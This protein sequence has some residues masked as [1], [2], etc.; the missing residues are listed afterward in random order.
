[1]LEKIL[2]KSHHILFELDGAAVVVLAAAGV[3]FA[4]PLAAASVQT[5]TCKIFFFHASVVKI[6]T[7]I[8]RCFFAQSHRSNT[9][10]GVST[11][12]FDVSLV[13]PVG[14][15]RVF[16]NP[17]VTKFGVSSISYYNHCM[18]H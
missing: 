12:N 2:V 14:A 4:E 5:Q 10:L 16:D 9:T 13:S 1:M 17:I 11:L 8:Q 15:P 6:I 3:V 18:I 7:A